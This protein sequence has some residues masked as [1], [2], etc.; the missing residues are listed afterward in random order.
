MVAALEEHELSRGASVLDVFTGSGVLGVSAALLG[1]RAVMA[2]DISWRAVLNARMNALLNGVQLRARRGDL[3]APVAEER[4]DLVLANPP[5]VPGADDE[6]PAG[7][8][9][10]AWEGGRSGRLRSGWEPRS[11]LESGGLWARSPQSAPNCSS[12]GGCFNLANGRRKCW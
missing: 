12:V 5:Y 3:F 2:T 10:R 8:A 9:E 11:C 4:F 6:L 7:G 1:A